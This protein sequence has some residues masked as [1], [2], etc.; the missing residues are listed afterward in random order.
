MMV[1]PETSTTRSSGSAGHSPT[2]AIQPSTIRTLPSDTVPGSPRVTRRPPS[3]TSEP[4]ARARGRRRSTGW[5][6]APPPA[7]GSYTVIR[8]PLPR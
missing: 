5:C 4:E 3:K 1:F 6:T 7:S 8:G 2:Q